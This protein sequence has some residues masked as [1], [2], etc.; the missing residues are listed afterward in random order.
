MTHWGG[1]S[2]GPVRDTITISYALCVLANPITTRLILQ[3]CLIALNDTRNVNQRAMVT[4]ARQTEK[5][6]PAIQSISTGPIF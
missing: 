1:E 3:D 4:Q 2:R 5:G 6:P